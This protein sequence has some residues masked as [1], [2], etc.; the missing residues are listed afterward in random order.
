MGRLRHGEQVGLHREGSQ[1]RS[2]VS[3]VLETPA[4]C[5]KH[6]N[7]EGGMG[8]HFFRNAPRAATGSCRR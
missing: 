6:K 4:L 8:I 5:I 3:P 2:A 1:Q 7:E